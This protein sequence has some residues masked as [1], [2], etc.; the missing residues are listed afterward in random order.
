MC[1][2]PHRAV[3]AALHVLLCLI[4]VGAQK[5]D[6][7]TDRGNAILGNVSQVS[8]TL[9][10]GR[11][12]MRRTA[13]G[14]SVKVDDT[15]LRCAPCKWKL[16]GGG[17][18]ISFF[19]AC[20]IAPGF[21]MCFCVW[22]FLLHI[23]ME[24]KIDVWAGADYK[25]VCSWAVA[26]KSPPNQLR[27]AGCAR[28]PLLDKKWDRV[29]KLHYICGSV[30]WPKSKFMHAVYI[31]KHLDGWWACWEI[32]C[33]YFLCVFVKNWKGV[34]TCMLKICSHMYVCMCGLVCGWLM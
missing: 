32:H 34:P 9:K 8:G 27:L 13:D 5:H 31:L 2:H 14:V 17:L 10:Y 15:V 33:L 1:A 19:K 11:W 18:T 12:R 16:R 3:S 24:K 29:K 23:E 25:T 6:T 4:T 28:S 20:G 30:S 21:S 7:L 26:H 22:S